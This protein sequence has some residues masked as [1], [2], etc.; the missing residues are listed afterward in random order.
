MNSSTT[1]RAHDTNPLATEVASLS[2]RERRYLDAFPIARR[3]SC[4]LAPGSPLGPY[5]SPSLASSNGV[6]SLRRT[7]TSVLQPRDHREAFEHH[8]RRIINNKTITERCAHPLST[9]EAFV[10]RPPRFQGGVTL[11][12]TVHV[13]SIDLA[14]RNDADTGRLNQRNGSLIRINHHPSLSH[15]GQRRLVSFVDLT[16][17]VVAVFDPD[18]IASTSRSR[19]SPGSANSAL[20]SSECSSLISTSVVKLFV[21][22]TRCSSI[23]NRCVT[24]RPQFNNEDPSEQ[25]HAHGSPHSGSSCN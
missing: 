3:A 2:H 12:L 9:P 23:L 13:N 15:D 16:R 14:E 10:R 18:K 1:P 25:R 20:G 7:T 4:T 21:H 22:V 6:T 5:D 11:L 8:E 24:R 17:L 19:S